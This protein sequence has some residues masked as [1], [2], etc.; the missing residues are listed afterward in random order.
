MA[1]TVIRFVFLL[2][3]SWNIKKK[4][5]MQISSPFCVNKRKKYNPCFDHRVLKVIEVKLKAIYVFKYEIS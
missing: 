1:I 2:L 3:A 5:Q 4:S